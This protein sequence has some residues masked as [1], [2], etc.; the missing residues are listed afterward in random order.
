MNLDKLDRVF[1]EFIRLRDAYDNGLVRCICC[2]KFVPW[3]Q[4]DAG[5]FINRKHLSLRFS[6]INVNAQCR[7]CNRFDEGNIPAYGL[8]LQ[9][10]YG[11]DIIERLL[12][13]KNTTVKFSQFEIDE[14]TKGYKILVSELKKKKGL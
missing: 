13:A 5:H 1:S 4:S 14:L 11:K 6:E 12:A 2:N 7:A 3:R 10:I 8:N 9:K